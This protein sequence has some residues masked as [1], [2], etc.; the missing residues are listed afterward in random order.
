MA[1]K[2]LSC[3]IAIRRNTEY[4]IRDDGLTCRARPG[5]VDIVSDIPLRHVAVPVQEVC[6]AE[7]KT[8]NN[9]TFRLFNSFYIFLF[10]QMI[11]TDKKETINK[12]FVRQKDMMPKPSLQQFGTFEH[13]KSRN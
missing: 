11:R 9:Q 3:N 2:S 13:K 7:N 4:S 12:F 10:V 8:N 1:M 6:L 5:I